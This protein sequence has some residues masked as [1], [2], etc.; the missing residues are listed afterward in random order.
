MTGTAIEINEMTTRELRH[1]S[2]NMEPQ[3]DTDETLSGTPT[4]TEDSGNLTLTGKAVSTA[5]LSISGVS[6]AIGQ[7]V[8]FTVDAAESGSY[9]IVIVC[10]TSS[11]Q[12]VDLELIVNVC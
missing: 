4:V 1:F 8:Q 6:V 3:L 9:T 5:L 7:A 12:T 10:G 11:G 2:V